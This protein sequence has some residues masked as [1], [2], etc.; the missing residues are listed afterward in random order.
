MPTK[1]TTHAA[2]VISG[3]S[4]IVAGGS[5]KD[6]RNRLDTV[7][8]VDTDSYS[9]VVNCQPRLYIPSQRLPCIIISI[10]D[11]RLY[12]HAGWLGETNLTH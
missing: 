11:E 12:M 9:A 2:A 1:L 8:V 4:L 7:E 10:C 3:H 5:Y 6:R